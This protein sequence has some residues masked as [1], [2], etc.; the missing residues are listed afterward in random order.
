M[1]HTFEEF[2]NPPKVH[3]AMCF[4]PGMARAEPQSGFMNR[5]VVIAVRSNEVQPCAAVQRLWLQA[6]VAVRPRCAQPCV[7]VRNLVR[8][9]F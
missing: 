5:P 4:M 3:P 1:S 8:K 7:T 6:C 2:L 9:H